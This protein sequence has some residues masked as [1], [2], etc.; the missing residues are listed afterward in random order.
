V[1]EP[2]ALAFTCRAAGPWW[3]PLRA[4]LIATFAHGVFGGVSL[5]TGGVSFAT[6]R[7]W[8]AALAISLGFAG[9]ILYN[10]EFGAVGVLLGT[11][12]L[13]RLAVGPVGEL[14]EEHR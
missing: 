11:L 1:V 7:P 12:R 2:E 5:V 14:R 10:Y 6:R 9:L 13:A 3:C 4:A 8:V